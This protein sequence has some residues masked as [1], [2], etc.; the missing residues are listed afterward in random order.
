MEQQDLA[1]GRIS[2]KLAPA[3]WM[4]TMLTSALAHN[5]ADADWVD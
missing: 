5:L 4:P 3:D 1:K 2:Y